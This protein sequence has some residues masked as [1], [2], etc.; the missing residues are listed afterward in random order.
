MFQNRNSER[1]CSPDDW[2]DFSE[3]MLVAIR[4]VASKVTVTDLALEVLKQTKLPKPKV[5]AQCTLWPKEIRQRLANSILSCAFIQ[6][7]TVQEE[8][9]RPF[10]PNAAPV[11]QTEKPE[12]KRRQRQEPVAKEP[13]EERKDL[14]PLRIKVLA[15]FNC[16]MAI[17]LRNGKCA[18]DIDAGEVLGK[19]MSMCRMRLK[20]GRTPEDYVK[21]PPAWMEE[22]YY[23]AVEEPYRVMTIN[24]GLPIQIND[25]LNS[26]IKQLSQ[27]LN[28][29]EQKIGGGMPSGPMA[30][31]VSDPAAVRGL[32]ALVTAIAAEVGERIEETLGKVTE[33]NRHIFGRLGKL[34]EGLKIKA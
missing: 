12:R 34:E 4:K 11:V 6:C 14:T 2:R 28:A 29:M 9:L 1:Y 32:N 3:K 30:G 21:A 16:E 7:T 18:E 26:T 5:R 10:A 25:G 8:S 24:H 13:E 19:A 23:Q 31:I 17:L 15:R 33:Q 20:H 27:R 22:L